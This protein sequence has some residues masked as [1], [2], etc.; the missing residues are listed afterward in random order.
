MCLC[1]FVILKQSKTAWDGDMELSPYS[2]TVYRASVHG[3]YMFCSEKHTRPLSR[4]DT[5][6]RDIN[7]KLATV[8]HQNY[9]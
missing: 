3:V 4:Q 7:K 5:Y 8:Q 9:T 2:W 1:F 6:E